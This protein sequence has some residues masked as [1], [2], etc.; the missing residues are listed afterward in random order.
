M[1]RNVLERLARFRHQKTEF[2]YP[3][4][5]IGDLDDIYKVENIIR[6]LVNQFRDSAVALAGDFPHNIIRWLW[7]APGYN[8]EE[9][10][11]LLCQLSTG[12]YAL[13]SARC[14]YTG[15]DCQGDMTIS[16]CESLATLIQYG[17]DESVYQLYMKKTMD[18]RFVPFCPNLISEPP[19][20]TAPHY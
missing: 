7:S 15:F 8:D 19:L 13:Y 20:D 10:W 18:A 4:S 14:D 16:V 17:M 12:A 1:S 9:C 5:C 2:D 3:F 11:Y 6:P